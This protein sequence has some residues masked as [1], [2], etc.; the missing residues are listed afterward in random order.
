MHRPWTMLSRSSSRR[1]VA[2]CSYAAFYRENRTIGRNTGRI[3]GNTR[4]RFF[5]PGRTRVIMVQ[6]DA[7][8]THR[9]M[10]RP[11]R[12]PRTSPERAQQR[13]QQPAPHRPPSPVMGRFQTGHLTGPNPACRPPLTTTRRRVFT[14]KIAG[15]YRCILN[16]LPNPHNPRIV[17]QPVKKVAGT[18]QPR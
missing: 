6:A 11:K 17:N 12:R 4:P 7:Q 2:S 9:P 16:F 5:L 18:G 1:R 10:H 13:A 3:T 14:P 15:V 8:A